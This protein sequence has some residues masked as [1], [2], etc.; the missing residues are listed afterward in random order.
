MNLK[1]AN[2]NYI[3]QNSNA[4]I[5]KL[6]SFIE[7]NQSNEYKNYEEP[8][9]LVRLTAFI[10]VLHKLGI[11]MDGK[12]M[13][14]VLETLSRYQ[15]VPLSRNVYWSPHAFIGKHAK[16]LV[17]AQNKVQDCLK[18]YQ[19]SIEKI[20]SNDLKACRQLG[21]QIALWSINMER[22]FA[23]G[24]IG[25]LKTFSKLILLG[26]GY[27]EQVN[28]LIDGLIRRHLA[29]SMPIT[30]NVLFTIYKLIQF[31]Q[32][33]QKTFARNQ[34]ICIRLLSSLLQWQKLKIQHLLLLTK[35]NILD[36]KLM[37]RKINILSTLKLSERSIKGYPTKRR[38]TV[39]NLALSE[40][41]GKDRI[42][43]ADKQKLFKSISLR[44]NNLWRYQQNILGQFDSTS[45]M[46]N[47]DSLSLSDAS[48]KEYVQQQ[49]NPFL[50]QVSWH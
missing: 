50:L 31:L 20:N 15:R 40:F 14:N 16:S 49:Q 48:L 34:I 22:V 18:Q 24:P 7:T 26:Q 3:T 12:L 28:S 17:K 2:V 19:S 29:L 43:P 45:L 25:Q 39:V 37:Q 6:I 32:I 9:H 33:L 27:G 23:T 11:L 41:L 38:F 10:C 47:Y 30:K 44:A 46:T 13:K 5:R 21:T 36:L 4:Y 1:D 42:L 35:K 8:K